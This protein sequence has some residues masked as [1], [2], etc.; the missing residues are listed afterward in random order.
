M[1]TIVF[2]PL[3]D[4]VLYLIEFH[5]FRLPIHFYDKIQLLF[6]CP[7]LDGHC[8]TQKLRL[9][10]EILLG[11]AS[12]SNGVYCLGMDVV[13]VLRQLACKSIYSI[14]LL[15]AKICDEFQMQFSV[16]IYLTLTAQCTGNC[17]NAFRVH[18]FSY[19]AKRW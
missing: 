19:G 9:I 6:L 13:R 11:A 5:F 17:L 1:G 10:I 15:L 18:F 12:H 3:L 14:K 8:A 16:S 4:S 7:I 2:Y